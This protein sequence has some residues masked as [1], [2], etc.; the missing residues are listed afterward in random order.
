MSL[1][2]LI[3]LLYDIYKNKLFILLF[4]KNSHMLSL[5]YSK[6]GVENLTPH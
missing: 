6:A 1:S 4:D 2:L 5:D 3:T